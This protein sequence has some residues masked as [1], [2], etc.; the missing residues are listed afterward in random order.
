M[1]F[2]VW[3]GECPDGT[4]VHSE[5]ECRRSDAISDPACRTVLQKADSL[6]RSAATVYPTLDQCMQHYGQCVRSA[7]ADGFKPLPVGFCVTASGSSVTRL[8]AIDHRQNLGV[9]WERN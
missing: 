8:G 7:V 9:N 1:A 4:I 6:M 3:R 2:I 5:A